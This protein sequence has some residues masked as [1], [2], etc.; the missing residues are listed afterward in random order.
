MTSNMIQ[1]K[2]PKNEFSYNSNWT[3]I[4]KNTAVS[5]SCDKFNHTCFCYSFLLR[6]LWWSPVYRCWKV[7]STVTK[8]PN[9]ATRQWQH[10]AVGLLFQQ[11]QRNHF[12]EIEGRVDGAKPHDNCWQPIRGCKRLE[13]AWGGFPSSRAATINLHPELQWTGVDRSTFMC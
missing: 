2:L 8:H 5:N 10:H 7:N 4:M 13:T 12:E 11:G 1:T 9:C 6:F 3:I